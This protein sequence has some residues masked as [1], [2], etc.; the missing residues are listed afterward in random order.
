MLP[1]IFLFA[2]ENIGQTIVGNI[3]AFI[4][5]LSISFECTNLLYQVFN[6]RFLLFKPLIESL[7]IQ[8]TC[9]QNKNC[10]YYYSLHTRG[11]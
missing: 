6:L 1:V 10:H 8:K 9:A 3:I 4:N 5:Y 11:Y 2:I 7:S